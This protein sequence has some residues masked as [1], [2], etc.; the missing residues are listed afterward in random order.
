[1][2]MALGDWLLA[3]GFK[4]VDELLVCGD[5]VDLKFSGQAAGPFGR[6]DEL[7]LLRGRRGGIVSSRSREERGVVVDQDVAGDWLLAYSIAAASFFYYKV[8][9]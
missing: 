7:E 3:N 6:E 8:S 2:D 4:V 5:V 1:M 9:R